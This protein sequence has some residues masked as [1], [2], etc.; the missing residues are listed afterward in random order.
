MRRTILDEESGRADEHDGYSY[1]VSKYH[2]A[3]RH[4]W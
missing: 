2:S 3:D 1:L 4:T